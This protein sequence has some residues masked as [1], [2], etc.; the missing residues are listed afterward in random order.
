MPTIDEIVSVNVLVQSAP[1]TPAG[2]GRA[3]IF[4]V[5]TRFAEDFRLYTS[6][7]GMLDD[8]FLATD[9][10]TVEATSLLAQS[11]I[12][13]RRVPDFYQARRLTP[14]AQQ[15]DGTVTFD[16]A[17]TV[18]SIIGGPNHADV[19]IATATNTTA[20][21]TAIDHAADINGDVT[22]GPLYTATPVGDDVQLVSDRPGVPFIVTGAGTGSADI[23]YANVV[24]NVGLP[25]DLARVLAAGA[26]WY[27]SLTTDRDSGDI[28]AFS[29]ATEATTPVKILGAQSAEAAIIF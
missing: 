24:P 10:E 26:E 17:Q 28:E 29:S 1:L 14:V 6:I 7:Q 4:G 2:F 13:G 16:A 8:G 11:A 27:C 22:L 3:A 25:E 12:S 20:A 15:D 5:H 21:Q 9:P 19:T 18:T 23:S